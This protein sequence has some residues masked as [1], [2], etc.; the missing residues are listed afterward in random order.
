MTSVVG[1]AETLSCIFFLLAVVVYLRAVSF[2]C[3][4][5]LG[6]SPVSK[7]S[8]VA[9]SMFF[10]G[11]SMLSKEQGIT[12]A[13]VCVV[14]DVLL[15]WDSFV[16]RVAEWRGVITKNATAGIVRTVRSDEKVKISRMMV[17]VALKRISESAL[18]HYALTDGPPPPPP[19]RPPTPCTHGPGFVASTTALLFYLRMSMNNNSQPIFKPEEMKAAFHSDFIVRYKGGGGGGGG[20]GGVPVQNN[21]YTPTHAHITTLSTCG[22]IYE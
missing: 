19:P 9:L 11:C 3:G 5:S 21:T 7:W 13:G 10:T 1:R 16:K 22:I 4:H 18:Y 17:G 2:G 12:A 14:C 8:Y 6:P 20:G 15:N